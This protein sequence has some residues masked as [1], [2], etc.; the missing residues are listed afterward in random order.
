MGNATLRGKVVTGL[1]AC[2]ACSG[3]LAGVGEAT[4][5]RDGGG[6][7]Q[8]DRFVYCHV[9]AADAKRMQLAEDLARRAGKLG[10]TGMV[11]QGDVQY[12]WMY[13]A[14][15]RERLLAL[16]RV[17]DDAGLEFVPGVWSIGYGTMLRAD[18]NLAAGMPVRDVPYVASADGRTAV[19]EPTEHPVENGG[20]E[21]VVAK[22]DGTFALP[23]WLGVDAPGRIAFVDRDV[24]DEGGQ[25]IRFELGES[26]KAK[27]PQARAYRRIALRPNRQY[28]VS[29]RLRTEGL[30][31]TSGFQI[32]VT[33]APKD[34]E[35]SGG[36]RIMTMNRPRIGRTNDW[37]T[38]TAEISTLESERLDVFVGSWKARA[39][40]FWLDDFR[41]EEL[42]LPNVLR[43]PGCPFVVA[44]AATKEVYR[45]GVDYDEVPPLGRGQERQ[46]V[47]NRS[48]VLKLRDGGRIAPGTRLL[49]SAYRSHL[50]KQSSQRCTCM[51]EPELYRLFAQS[52]RAIADELHPRKWFLPLDEV[53]MGGTCAACEARHEDMAH[54]LA[55]CIRRQRQIIRS[56]TPEAE[57]FMWSDMIN[58]YQN[59]KEQVFMCKGSF[60]GGADLIPK[61]IVVVQWSEHKY[62][63]AMAFFRDKGF[64]TVWSC[65][66]DGGGS[67]ASG[68]PAA[69]RQR[70]DCVNRDANCRGFMFTTWQSSYPDEK[71]KVFAEGIV[72]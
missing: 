54:I 57:I 25:S 44:D 26:G 23:G 55:D 32:V 22:A 2:V 52:A 67:W 37:M 58:P 61:D 19:F 16:K 48:L 33:K 8:F 68:A 50:M 28:R 29:V 13:S 31:T 71:L 15:E 49:V 36:T 72:R 40:R 10:Y 66:A 35:Q 12:L 9:K 56:V 63:E 64:R 38:L 43:R 5:V 65:N 20:F 3:A 46:P 70:I 27:D 59:A 4:P 30:D 14:E 21:T 34:G 7:A 11:F 6:K 62:D 39:G 51:S 17:C 53:R 60:V 1:I 47:K 45:A 69:V 42:G 24:R 41:L 18:P